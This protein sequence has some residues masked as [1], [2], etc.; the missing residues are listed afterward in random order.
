MVDH[1]AL[2]R[3]LCHYGIRGVAHKWLECYLSNR[4]QFVSVGEAKSP[5]GK[6]RYG[7]PRGFILGPPLFIIYINDL[8]G[9]SKL[10]KCILYADDA[11]IIISGNNVHEIE[12]QVNLLAER[13]IKWVNANGLLINLKKTNYILS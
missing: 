12:N 11:N 3:K 4:E 6:M 2:L 5:C 9:I 8:P 7:V 13:L 10:A 1:R